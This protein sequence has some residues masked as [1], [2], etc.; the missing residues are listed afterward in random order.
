MSS[1]LSSYFP[2]LVNER[3]R[4]KLLTSQIGLSAS[5]NS[6]VNRNRTETSVNRT[7][8]SVNRNWTEKIFSFSVRFETDNPTHKLYASQMTVHVGMTG[9][10]D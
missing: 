5:A 9:R 10:H 7:E 8:L 1:D 3:E 6:S 4:R 2:R